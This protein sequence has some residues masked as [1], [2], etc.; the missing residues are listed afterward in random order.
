MTPCPPPLPLVLMFILL[1]AALGTLAWSLIPSFLPPCPTPSPDAPTRS[2]EHRP[3]PFLLPPAST[4]VTPM[5]R[6]LCFACAVSYPLPQGLG[7]VKANRVLSSGPCLG[8]RL[9]FLLGDPRS[10]LLSLGVQGGC[11]DPELPGVP[12][13]LGRG[14]RPSLDAWRGLWSPWG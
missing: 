5:A 9:L 6:A 4:A 11:Q 10:G 13:V 7:Q 1:R 8:G 12:C 14:P 2:S 3:L